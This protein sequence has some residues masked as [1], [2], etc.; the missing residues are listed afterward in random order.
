MQESGTSLILEEDSIVETNIFG[1]TIPGHEGT[2]LEL[3]SPDTNDLV[4]GQ[5][6]VR[7]ETL[8]KS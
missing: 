8:L 7:G 3:L 1:L 2:T 6:C 4:M 5:P